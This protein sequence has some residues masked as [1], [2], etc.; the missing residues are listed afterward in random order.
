MSTTAYQHLLADIGRDL[1]ESQAEEFELRRLERYLLRK[2]EAAVAAPGGAGDGSPPPEVG[3][4][5]LDLLEAIRRQL[6]DVERVL[7]ELRILDTRVRRLSA[8]P[9]NNGQPPAAGT[10]P[11]VAPASVESVA[12]AVGGGDEGGPEEPLD[13]RPEDLF[14]RA[15]RIPST[16]RGMLKGPAASERTAVDCTLFTSREVLTG[17]KAALFVVCHQPAGEAPAGAR[18]QGGR[19]A[20]DG[21]ACSLG[22]RVTRDSRLAFELAV[23]GLPI[24]NAR[25]EIVWT[26][27]DQFA[28]FRVHL[29]ETFHA[30][31]TLGKLTVVQ[32]QVPIGRIRFQWKLATGGGA[33]A[34]GLEP[35]GQAQRYERAYLCY[36]PKDRPAVEQR[37]RLLK[38]AGLECVEDNLELDASQR[39]ARG[40]Y[41]QIDACDVLFL[42]WSPAAAESA[43]IQ[44]EW[45]YA[46]KRH[47]GD[48]IYPML[49]HGSLPAQL[50]FLQPARPSGPRV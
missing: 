8:R 13:P 17:S 39:W 47:G 15:A 7:D 50:A 34:T 26:G 14:A 6:L 42:F 40:L 10:V 21:E 2:L 45:Q 23:H 29:P 35:A 12:A 31:S 24:R 32:D 3:E 28:E 9:V 36:A 16:A 19:A 25:R 30:D 4:R 37:L 46:L 44:K 33:A 43:W 1:D 41:R 27:G 48:F 11:V 18:R 22:A 5:R 38:S 20:P 49:L